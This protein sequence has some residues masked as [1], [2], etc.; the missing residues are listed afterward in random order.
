MW[1]IPDCHQE[2]VLTFDLTQY[3]TENTTYRATVLRQGGPGMPQSCGV[4]L[5]LYY[6][7]FVMQPFQ[8]LYRSMS[9]IILPAGISLTA[10]QY[11]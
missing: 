10:V 8:S 4:L 6:Y 7:L 1:T 9:M 11:V 3:L 5:L 2:S